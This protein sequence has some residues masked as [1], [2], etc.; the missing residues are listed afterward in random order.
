MAGTV[1][2]TGPAPARSVGAGSTDR[3]TR[4]LRWPAAGAF[5]D[6]DPA[7]YEDLAAPHTPRLGPID[8]AGQA[9]GPYGTPVAKS[10]G[11]LEEIGRASCRER[12]ERRGRGEV[13]RGRTQLRK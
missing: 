13:T 11:G 3:W 4:C 5:T 2:R 7:I 6:D 12:G 10:L 8:G 9:L 1:G